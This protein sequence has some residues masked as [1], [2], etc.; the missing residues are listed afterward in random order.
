MRIIRQQTRMKNIDASI[1]IHNTGLTLLADES[2]LKQMLVNLL[3]NAV[4]FT[5]EG[6]SIGLEVDGLEDGEKVRFCVW[7]T[8]IGIAEDKQALLFRPFVQV[9]PA[10]ARQYDGTGLGLSLVRQLAELHGGTVNVE[11]RLGK[12]SRFAIV[13]PA[14][15]KHLE[16]TALDFLESLPD[17]GAVGAGQLIM[18]ADDNQYN[19]MG[20]ID[21]LRTR[22]YRVLSAANGREAIEQAMDFSPDLMLIDIQMPEVDGLEVIR[23]IRAMPALS[24][25]PIIALTAMAMSGDRERCLKAGA[26]DYMAKPVELKDL[27]EKIQ[28]MLRL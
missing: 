18:I 24:R 9:N 2:R 22:G 15:K 28:T 6:G 11:S 16:N 26:D 10:L 5:P 19:L 17:V 4:K 3:S 25:R 13:L 14:R 1:Q 27:A 7:D 23:R 12:G 20:M 21:Y 8:G